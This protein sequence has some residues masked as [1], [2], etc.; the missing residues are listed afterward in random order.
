MPKIFALFVASLAVVSSF[1]PSPHLLSSPTQ[2]LASESNHVEIQQSRQAFLKS[3]S[4]LIGA[5]ALSLVANPAPS[6]ARGRA[7]LDNAY[8]RYTPRILA[9]GDFYGGA[10]RKLVEKGDWAGIKSSLAEPPKRSKEDKAKIDGGIAERA[11]LAGQFSDARVIVACELYAA[12]FSDNSLSAKTKKMKAQV[13]ILRQV[14]AEMTST[15]QQGLGEGGGGGFFGMG[16]KKLSQ[17]ELTKKMRELYQ[18]G[19]NAWNQYIFAANEEL[20]LQLK[21]L[22]YLR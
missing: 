3:S 12:G 15:A 8:D 1:Q 6:V 22:P 4:L 18:S 21:K 19:G 5:G 10:F 2:L 14:V 20:P 17:G 16:G 9:G 13:E 11:A 7:T